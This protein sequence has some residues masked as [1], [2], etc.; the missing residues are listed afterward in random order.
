MSEE[1]ERTELENIMKTWLGAIIFN[2]VTIQK[3]NPKFAFG[4]MGDRYG[5]E[6]CII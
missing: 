6:I 2:M 1:K 5:A 4:P 3:R